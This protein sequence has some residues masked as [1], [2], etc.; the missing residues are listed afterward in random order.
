[1]KNQRI[2]WAIEISNAPRGDDS[3]WWVLL[4]YRASQRADAVKE[5]KRQRR[6]CKG[7]KVRVR[8]V[9]YVPEVRKR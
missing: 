8:L 2:I 9:K 4:L 6:K 5:R 1:M 3:Q 7:S